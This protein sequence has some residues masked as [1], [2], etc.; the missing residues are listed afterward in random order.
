MKNSNNKFTKFTK[1]A[2]VLTKKEA[3]NVKGGITNTDV[4][5][6]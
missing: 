6:I 2:K 5:V 4:G 1:N 3:K